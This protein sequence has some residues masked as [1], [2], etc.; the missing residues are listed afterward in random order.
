MKKLPSIVFLSLAASCSVS[1]HALYA[2]QTLNHETANLHFRNAQEYFELKHYE[3]ARAEFQLFLDE[4]RTF[5]DKEDAN[6][7]WAEYYI[8]LCS[9]YM[10]RPETELMTDRFVR[11]YPEHPIAGYIFR[12]IGNYFFDNGDYARAVDYLSKSGKNDEAAQYRLGVAHFTLQN[13]AQAMAIFNRL[14][15]STHPEFGPGAA[16]YA[17]VLQYRAGNY[18]D[19]IAAFK[20]AEQSPNLRGEVP[21]W[22][23][24]SYF[25]QGK[26]DEMLTYAEGVLGERSSGKKLDDLSLLTAEVY[27]QRNNFERSAYYYKLYKNFKTLMLPA[28]SY[29]YGYSLYKINQFQPATDQLKT[30]ATAQDTLAQYASFVMGICQQRT[31]NL[32]GAL[33]SFDKASR[34]SFSLPIKEEAALNYA[35]V[36]LELGRAPEATKALE[37]FIQNYPSGAFRAEA[38]QLLG[39]SYFTE[40]NYLAA[41]NYIERLPQRS[42]SINA[43]YQKNTYRQAVKRFNEEGFVDAITFFDKSLSTPIDL[44]LRYQASFGKGEALSALKRYPESIPLYLGII[45]TNDKTESLPD[46]QQKSRYAVA[47]SYYTNKEYD[48]ANAYFK[49]YAEKGLATNPDSKAYQDALLRLGD[50]YYAQ[51][52]YKSALSTYDKAYRTNKINQDY[53]LFQKGIVFYAQGDDV[54]AKKTLEE[55]TKVF[56]SSNYVDKAWFK[57]AEKE[58]EARRYNTAITAYTRL[59]NDRPNSP[60]IAQAYIKRAGAFESADAKKYV[61]EAIADYKYVLKHYPNTEDASNALDGLQDLLENNDR[62][63]EFVAV[64]AEQQKANPS[65]PSLVAKEY[66]AAKSLYY[67][68][69]YDKAALALRDFVTKYPN[70]PESE[71]GSF[72]AAEAFFFSN[73]LPEALK[74]YH[75]V[76]QRKYKNTNKA[77]E[78]AAK[79]EFEGNSFVRAITSYKTLLGS[80]KEVRETQVALLGLVESYYNTPKTDSTLTYAQQMIN[81]KNIQPNAKNKAYLYAGKIYMQL[82]DYGKAED[83]FNQAI[84]IAKDDVGAEAQ[85]MIAKMLYDAKRYKESSDI[86]RLKFGATGE[87]AKAS[88]ALMGRAYLLMADDFIALGN[89][90]QA[91]ATLNSI[92][93]NLPDENAVEQARLKLRTLDK[94]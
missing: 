84:V 48:K 87:F 28:A 63:E 54:N 46:L 19:A 57:I 82:K 15:N 27:F 40:N 76:M 53:A 72:L 6:I 65:D 75:L 14:K 67:V 68:P 26:Y 9:L 5:L 8:I 56:P 86:L 69:K 64:V 35:K 37:G 89:I 13:D 50:T 23:A 70:A 4:H 1:H 16:Y 7:P 10:D 41:V 91:K 31:N 59:I 38:D 62:S 94:K 81:D 71:E 17:G 44:D 51:K 43:L 36:L 88:D 34:L 42:P 92:I 61:E 45:K 90:T 77:A 49:E 25:K 33:V 74:Y 93:A 80:A 47:Y 22:I 11:T 2:Q 29:R 24:N 21:A 12:E 18:D 85:I 52:D 3:A 58:A 83:M 20:V 78:R 73:N 79:I 66:E 32:Q 60:L 55:L 30:I 39:E